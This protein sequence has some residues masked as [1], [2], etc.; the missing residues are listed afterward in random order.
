MPRY[1]FNVHGETFATSDLV[2]RD[3]SGDEAARLEA[4]LVANEVAMTA[5]SSAQLLQNPWV[6]VLDDNQRPI[7]IIPVHEAIAAD[8][9]RAE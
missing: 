7:V 4:K 2:G 5:L 9:N 1:F 6:E 8:P 3:L